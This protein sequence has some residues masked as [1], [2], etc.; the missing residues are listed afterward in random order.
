MVTSVAFSPDGTTIL[1]GS[2]D[3]TARMWSLNHSETV[4]KW[5]TTAMLPLE[6]WLI[7]KASQARKSHDFFDVLENSF[8]HTIFMNI[9]SCVQEYIEKWYYKSPNEQKT[10]VFS[11]I[12]KTLAS[13]IEQVTADNL[14]TTQNTFS[15]EDTIFIE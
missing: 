5:S 12:N 7:S 15:S 14:P 1:T 3:G 13:P 11:S 8:E 10:S 9:P 6:A 4:K 2:Y